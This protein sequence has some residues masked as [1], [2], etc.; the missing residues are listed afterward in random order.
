MGFGGSVAAMIASINA[1]KRTR[2]STF[3]KL[4]NHKKRKNTKLH[5]NN[6]ANKEEL[7]LLKNKILRESKINA[8]WKIGFLVVIIILLIY[9]IGFVEM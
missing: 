2:I 7:S 3:D 4:K 5:F 1:N 9:A 8:L 6:K